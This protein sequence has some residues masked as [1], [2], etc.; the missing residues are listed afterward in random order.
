MSGRSS[1]NGHAAK[2]TPDG[3]LHFI[4]LAQA[5]AVQA[6]AIPG[7]TNDS[8]A[9]SF[10]RAVLRP[11]AAMLTPV[12]NIRPSRLRHEVSDQCA[13]SRSRRLDDEHDRSGTA[14]HAE[15][16]QNREDVNVGEQI[17]EQHQFRR[18]R[19]TMAVGQDKNKDRDKSNNLPPCQP[20]KT[21]ANCTMKTSHS[22]SP[23]A[24]GLSIV[25]F[26]HRAFHIVLSV[27]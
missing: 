18:Y 24:A 3:S 27:T 26:L 1:G 16:K 11:L 8:S 7:A 25:H 2:A 5:L 19:D 4:R 9:S 12:S 21:A 23:K 17:A 20:I 13:C 14:Q 10:D 6:H 22:Q 15:K